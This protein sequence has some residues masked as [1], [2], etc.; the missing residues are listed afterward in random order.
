[1]RGIHKRAVFV[2][3]REGKVRYAWESQG[4]ALPNDEEILAEVR[5]L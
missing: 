3:D 1:M 2:I 4:G 5:K